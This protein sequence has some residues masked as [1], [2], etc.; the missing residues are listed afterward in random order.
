MFCLIKTRQQR[1]LCSRFR[2][3]LLIASY[4]L[5][6]APYAGRAAAGMKT[7][8]KSPVL[9]TAGAVRK[10]S[11]DQAARGQPVRLGAVV[12]FYDRQT[13][14]LFVQDRTAG[15]FVQNARATNLGLRVGQL[16][17]LEGV[18]RHGQFGPVIA[19]PTIRAQG[20]GRLPSA[21]LLTAEK[22]FAGIED[23]QWV[24]VQ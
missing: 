11:S 10:L 4:S 22:L 20:K 19:D 3:L 5:L 23:A 7:P 6:F 14:Y 9:V 12:T 17:E 16:I 1:R 24:E 2:A 21:P 13:D 8:E 15:V 18:T